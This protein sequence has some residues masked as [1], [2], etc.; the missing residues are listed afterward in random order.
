MAVIVRRFP[1]LRHYSRPALKAQLSIHA[2]KI[3]DLD[4]QVSWLGFQFGA[5]AL[6]EYILRYGKQYDAIVFSPYMFWTTSVC[7]PFVAERAVVIP[8][9]HDELYARLEVLRPVLA[10]PQ[11][12]WFLSGPEHFLAHRLGPVAHTA[13]RDWRRCAG[14]FA[15]RPCRVHGK[16]PIG[17]PFRALCRAAGTGKGDRLAP[18]GLRR[19]RSKTGTSTLTW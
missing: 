10:D 9:L 6:F 8:C 18:R 7:V 2:G 11:L 12:V 15:L 14:P 5:P 16:A 3:P 19:V 17:A 1:V 4:H 13:Q